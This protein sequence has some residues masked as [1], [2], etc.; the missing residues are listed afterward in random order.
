LIVVQPLKDALIGDSRSTL[1]LLWAAVGLILL[2]A[3]VNV[4]HLQL[5]RSIERQKELAIRRALGSSRRRVMQPVFL[6]SLLLALIG[7]GAG[8]LLAYPTV[9]VL[10]AMAP[11]QL[12]RTSE[13]HLNGW[14]LGFALGLSL[15]TAVLSAML[16]AMRAAKVD[17]AEALKSDA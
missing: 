11:N 1:M 3:C 5:V 10:V 2:I 7:G 9:R 6:E 16:P 17:P 4:M 12:P 14:G 15:V 8:V 13:I